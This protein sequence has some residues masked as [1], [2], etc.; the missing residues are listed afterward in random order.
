MDKLTFNTDGTIQRVVPTRKGIDPVDTSDLI[1]KTTA[2][3]TV[4]YKTGKVERV[5]YYA[6]DGTSLGTVKPVAG[7][8]YIQREIMTD[9]S[10]HTRKIVV[11]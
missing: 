3:Q 1:K 9:G 6:I 11:K 5:V 7:G 10:S 4:G 2:V 8:L